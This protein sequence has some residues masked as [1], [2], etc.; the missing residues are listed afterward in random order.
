MLFTPTLPNMPLWMVAIGISFGV[1]LGKEIFATGK[2]FL[3][4]ALTARAFLF[5]PIPPKFQETGWG[6]VD[7]YS[8]ATAPSL[9]KVGGV[10]ES[11]AGA[12]PGG[13]PLSA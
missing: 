1:V 12:R 6:G 9:G 4:P 2:I 5:S 3:N 11:S 13:M 8:G 10:E 7:G